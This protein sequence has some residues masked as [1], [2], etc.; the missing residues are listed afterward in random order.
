MQRTPVRLLG[1][2]KQS[3][4]TF[5]PY[6]LQAGIQTAVSSNTANV[7]DCFSLLAQR[8]LSEMLYNH[9][10]MTNTAGDIYQ[11]QLGVEYFSESK[12]AIVSRT[13]KDPNLSDRG[14]QTF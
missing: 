1:K 10:L 9:G 13:P 14:K 6:W 4:S 2:M 7:S 11:S 5:E 12:N 3:I 8:N